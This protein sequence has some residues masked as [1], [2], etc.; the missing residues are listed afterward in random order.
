M[1]VELPSTGASI[2]FSGKADQRVGAERQKSWMGSDDAI[3]AG[4]IWHTCVQVAG[5]EI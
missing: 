2:T 1:R 3:V 4:M 5:A